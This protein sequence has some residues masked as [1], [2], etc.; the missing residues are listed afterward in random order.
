MNGGYTGLRLP[1]EVVIFRKE[2]MYKVYRHELLH[3]IEEVKGSEEKNEGYIETKASILS[4]I[5]TL[6]ELEIDHLK[7]IEEIIKSREIEG[8]YY[9]TKKRE[10]YENGLRMTR[11][12]T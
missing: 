6:I 12:C 7:R 9:Y 2:E 10:E 11:N 8:E 3:V 1:I 5:T 4:V